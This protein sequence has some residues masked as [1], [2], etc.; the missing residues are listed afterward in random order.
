MHLI[1]GTIIIFQAISYEKSV[2]VYL[3]QYGI[4]TCHMP[5]NCLPVQCWMEM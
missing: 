5:L 4:V 3:G 1:L 2:L